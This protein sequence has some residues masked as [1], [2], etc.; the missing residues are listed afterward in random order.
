MALTKVG[1]GV[2]NIDDL[3]GFRN[4]IINGD[5]RIDQRN[6]GAAVAISSNGI[7]GLD[8]FY[9]QSDVGSGSTMQRV[10]DAPSGFTYS[11]KLVVG[12][13]AIPTGSQFGRLI[14]FVEGFDSA[15]FNWTTPDAR[16]VTLSFWVKSS[17]TGT[18]GVSFKQQ[19]GSP[20]SGYFD[21][22][23]INSTNTWEYKTITIPAGVITGGTRSITNGIGIIMAWDLGEGPERSTTPGYVLGVDG[24]T[25]GLTGGTKIFATSGA[26]WQ[27]TGVQ[28]EAGSVATPFERRPFGT[29]LALCQRYYQQWGPDLG[30]LPALGEAVSTTVAQFPF[31]LPVIMRAEPTLLQNTTT[32][33]YKLYSGNTTANATSINSVMFSNSFGCWGGR[34]NIT[35]GSG[36]LTLKQVTQA[37]GEDPAFFGFNAEL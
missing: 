32:S 16:A 13:G 31:I 6:N 12:T 24:G 28:L 4:R 21:S 23:T 20:A 3:Y 8:R 29:E 19:T 33:L 30:R 5:M 35:V 17:V 22:Y 1:A 9:I 37:L 14:Y 36:F 26:T 2:L 7:F 25:L 11:N 15:D 10:V 34:I 27:I 18:F